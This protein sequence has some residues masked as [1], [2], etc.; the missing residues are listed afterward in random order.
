M[1][2]LRTAYRGLGVCVSNKVHKL[3]ACLS[4]G[5]AGGVRASMSASTERGCIGGV[6]CVGVETEPDLPL[7]QRRPGVKELVLARGRKPRGVSSS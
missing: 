5:T 1:M 3:L 6:G 2:G 7:L 4:D